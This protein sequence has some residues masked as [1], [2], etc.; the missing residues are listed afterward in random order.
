MS[1]DFEFNIGDLI[2]YNMARESA[3]NFQLG[4][5]YEIVDIGRV[6]A[7]AREAPSNA[8]VIWIESS[9]QDWRMWCEIQL[10]KHVFTPV[11]SLT[12]EEQFYITMS[13]VVPEE[14]IE[15]IKHE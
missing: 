9:E 2:I 10:A 12:E 15:R 14:V 11:S 1:D 13:G 4:N 6:P 8:K 5:L 7:S 3:C